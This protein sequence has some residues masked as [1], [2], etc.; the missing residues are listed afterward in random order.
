MLL[1]V[2]LLLIVFSVA[3]APQPAQAQ[4]TGAPAGG[5]T[6]V[7]VEREDTDADLNLSQPDFMVV[8]LPTTLRL[9]RFKSAFRV[10]HRFT[11]PLGQGDF[12]NLAEDFFGLDTGAV[13]GLE[14]RFGLA[15]GWQAGI[16]RT[17]DRTI[18][19]FTQYNLWGQAN[20]LVGLSVIASID[21]TDNFTDSY[22]PTLGAV[23]SRELGTW[24][25]LYL[26]PI[27]VNNTNPLPAEVVD[28]NDTF[29]V[30]IGTRIRI[31]P[32]LYLVGEVIPGT[33]FK[34]GV[35]HGTFG[36]EKR[37]GGHTF[38]ANFSNGV[39]STMGQIAR[40]GIGDDNW[41]LG[42]SISRKFF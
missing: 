17:S 24:G 29:M 18:E 37:L 12:G 16:Y 5:Q 27:W 30:G 1:R 4:D 36:F 40:G 42:F 21:G 13:I 8:T 15:R 23:I 28:D 22:S 33:G 6:T 34:P 39:G 14:Y 19:L 41:Y 10:T 31:R 35:S 3:L 32:T 20:R 25:A 11:R 9:P 7:Q 2:L 38:Q 26:E